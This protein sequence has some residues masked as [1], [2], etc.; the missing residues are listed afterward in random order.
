M[1]LRSEERF[2]SGKATIGVTVRENGSTRVLEPSPGLERRAFTWGRNQSGAEQLALALLRDALDDEEM[3]RRF[4]QRFS[5]RVISNFPDNWTVT[6]TRIRRSYQ[7][8]GPSAVRQK[9]R[10]G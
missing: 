5:R 3:A 7:H 9:R 6:R 4:H 10:S 8:D 1:T 2:Y